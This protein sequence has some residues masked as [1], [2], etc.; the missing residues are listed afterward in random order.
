[1]QFLT[2]AQLDA[3]VPQKV[4]EITD[5]TTANETTAADEITTTDGTAAANEAT[6]AN[7][8]TATNET[9]SANYTADANETTDADAAANVQNGQET[10]QTALSR[11]PKDEKGNPIYEQ[12]DAETA[13]DGIVEQTEGDE[14]MAQAVA[15]EMVADKEAALKKLEKSKSK[16]GATVAEKIASEKER[17]AAIDAA[18]EE[19]AAWKRIAGTANRRRMEA[20]AERRRIAEEAEALRKAEEEKSR[21]EREEAERVK[22]EALNGVPD[23]VDDTPQDA[24][25]RG[26][27]RVNGYK[28]EF[29]L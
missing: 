15:D 1:V 19:L 12:T 4:D 25:A 13:W 14:A 16:G 24:R 18:K 27:R 26:Y 29:Q 7:D 5:E 20:D 17:K 11:I 23:I 21:A 9:T 22:R 8:T 3:L 6:T 2:E 10:G 28:V